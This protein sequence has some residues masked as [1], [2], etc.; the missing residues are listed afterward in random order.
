[1]TL[2]SS[3]GS[4]RFAPSEIER[5][6]KVAHRMN[7]PR[8]T[9]YAGRFSFKETHMEIRSKREKKEEH[10]KEGKKFGK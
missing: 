7:P 1:M 6:A 5:P 8:R 3:S 10:K 4:K 9:H 2:S